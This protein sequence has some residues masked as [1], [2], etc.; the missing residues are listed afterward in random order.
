M[1]RQHSGISLLEVLAAIFVVTIG[2]LG[3]LAVIPFGAFQVTQANHAKY[4][5]NMLANAVEEVLLRDMAIPTGWGF[6]NDPIATTLFP[7]NVTPG[8]L[9]PPREV[10][11]RNL[12]PTQRERDVHTIT[13]AVVIPTPQLRRHTL[14]ESIGVVGVGVPVLVRFEEHFEVMIGCQM[15]TET[16][17]RT[18]DIHPDTGADIFGPWTLAA[19][20]PPFDVRTVNRPFTRNGGVALN[21]TRFIWFDSR[22]SDLSDL[23]HVFPISSFEPVPQRRNLISRWAEP[24]R[25]QDDLL[26]TIGS[27]RRPEFANNNVLSSG[28]YTWFFTYSPQPGTWNGRIHPP[29][30]LAWCDC[31]SGTI[32]QSVSILVGDYPTHDF[33]LLENLNPTATADVLACH[34]RVHGDDV[35]IQIPPGNFTRSLG[36]ATITL[37]GIVTF[38]GRQVDVVE[39][40]TQTNYVFVTWNTPQRWGSQSP[41]ANGA[42]CK[43]VFL[44]R[45]NLA[46]PRIVVTD[47]ENRLPP[48]ANNNNMQVY[49][50]SGVLFHK[51]TEGVSIR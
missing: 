44:D 45:S 15:V 22:E 29:S 34:N 41:I 24:M 49:I 4:A 50:P 9:P 18:H 11:V 42:W 3:V 8:S 43:I 48:N 37:P 20:S 39:R 1:T 23:S 13:S 35:Q 14:I 36:G 2:L 38:G 25:G 21:F 16:Y 31:G 26:Y 30:R 17:E 5:S 28:K 32:R 46:S 33:V 12:S 6:N 47:A 40:L 51:Q 10:S 27:N 7:L 19:T